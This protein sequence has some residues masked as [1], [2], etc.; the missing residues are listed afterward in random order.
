M[1]LSQMCCLSS[2][3]LAHLVDSQSN[4]TVTDNIRHCAHLM[5]IASFCASR[6]IT[7]D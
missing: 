7:Y 5:Y 1:I 2:G 3:T 6:L 4:V